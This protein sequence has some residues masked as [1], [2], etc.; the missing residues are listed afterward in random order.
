MGILQEFWQDDDAYVC[1]SMDELL[2]YLLVQIVEPQ[3]NTPTDVITWSNKTQQFPPIT[4][5][6]V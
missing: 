5:H 6:F 2:S 1:F 3:I 4:I